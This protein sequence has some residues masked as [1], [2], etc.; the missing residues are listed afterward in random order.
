MSSEER[1]EEESLERDAPYLIKMMTSSLAC[2]ISGERMPDRECLRSDRRAKNAG[3]RKEE[4]Q[5]RLRFL[6][7][8]KVNRMR[9]NKVE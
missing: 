9:R 7:T 8:N 5:L 1:K 6:E 3:I 2:V 4:D